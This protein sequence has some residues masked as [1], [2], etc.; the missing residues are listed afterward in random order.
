MSE[1]SL[2][3]PGVSGVLHHRF[4][5][6]N[7]VQFTRRRIT[8]GKQRPTER[9]MTAKFAAAKSLDNCPLA[10]ALQTRSLPEAVDRR[11]VE[12]MVERAKRPSWCQAGDRV[13]FCARAPILEPHVL[14]IASRPRPR[15]KCGDVVCRERG[16]ARQRQACYAINADGPIQFFTTGWRAVPA[17]TCANL[18]HS[19]GIDS[20][21]AK[22]CD[23]EFLCA[24]GLL[25]A[26]RAHRPIA[27]Q[28]ARALSVQ[29]LVFVPAPARVVPE[30]QVSKP[31][32]SPSSSHC[33]AHIRPKAVYC[34]R[35]HHSHGGG[36][37]AFENARPALTVGCTLA[38]PPGR[39]TFSI[40]RCPNQPNRVSNFRR[41]S[42]R[43]SSRT[44]AA[45]LL[46]PVGAW[47]F[48]DRT[49]S[50][51]WGPIARGGR[52]DVVKCRM[53]QNASVRTVQAN[54]PHRLRFATGG[55]HREV[56]ACGA[57]FLSQ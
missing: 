57:F 7:S 34:A 38:A 50:P 11:K 18:R 44:D 5:V 22:R 25:Y 31:A 37:H 39:C 8:R 1:L 54:K 35:L 2:Q 45:R 23:S 13:D 24:P 33:P 43:S 9:G 41:L 53:K 3:N 40:T 36:Q 32:L 28:G 21:S 20:H 14:N 29:E 26:R 27:Q 55:A 47:P 16:W 46:A 12:E 56:P 4:F 30:S 48:P 19:R 15:P 17:R 51:L 6:Q 52:N 42:S 49:I 10:A